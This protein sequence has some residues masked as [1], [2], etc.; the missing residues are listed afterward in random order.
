MYKKGNVNNDIWMKMI[1][2]WMLLYRKQ[3]FSQWLKN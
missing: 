3:N 2:E 1:S